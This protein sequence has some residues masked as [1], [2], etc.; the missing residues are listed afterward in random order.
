[1]RERKRERERESNESC[2]CGPLSLCAPVS[3]G[4]TGDAGAPSLRPWALETGLLEE[5]SGHP[6]IS[7]TSGNKHQ[8]HLFAI[9][10][11]LW[12]LLHSLK[13]TLTLSPHFLFRSTLLCETQII[14]ILQI[15]KLYL[16]ESE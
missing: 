14:A 12:T 16:D 5:V 11:D 7:G 2:V 4:W 15:S 1:M 10:L 6:A 3:P 8:G 9:T 13:N